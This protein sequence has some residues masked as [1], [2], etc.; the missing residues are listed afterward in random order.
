MK[1]NIDNSVNNLLLEK[2]SALN[3]LIN[4]FDAGEPPF[5]F[6]LGYCKEAVK[7]TKQVSYWMLGCG[8]LLISRALRRFAF[9]RK[10]SIFIGAAAIVMAIVYFIYASKMDKIVL[11][12]INGDSITVK[13][14]TYNS[15]DISEIK[16]AAMN[17]LK[18]MSYDKKVLSINKS[19]DGCA[20]LVRWAKKHYIPINDSNTADMQSIQKRNA[21]I[22][23]VTLVISFIVAFL[24]VFLKR[25]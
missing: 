3:S 16:G 18:V 22:V 15:S 2:I 9:M 14:R 12:E 25:M 13:G 7:Q 21:I 19:C 17:N 1:N 8:C 24:L 20:D 4:S 10:A 5:S 6:K 11:G 23:A